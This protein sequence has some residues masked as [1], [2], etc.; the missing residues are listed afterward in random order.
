MFVDFSFEN[1]DYFF[2]SQVLPSY[3]LIR[4]YLFSGRL[5]YSIALANIILFI[6]PT[7]TI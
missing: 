5:Y 1:N 2:P 4:V 3:K 7:F 6:N